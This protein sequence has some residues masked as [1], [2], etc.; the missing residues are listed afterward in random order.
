MRWRTRR[1]PSC[2]QPCVSPVSSR[3]LAGSVKKIWQAT[4][5]TSASLKP[6]SRGAR[7]SGATRMSLFSS[8]TISFLAARNT[9]LEPPPNPRFS[10]WSIP[11]TSGNL[12]RRKP[13]LPSLEPLSTTRISLAG[14]PASAT[15]MLGMYLASRSFPFQLGM[16]TV[17]VA[18]ALLAAAS[19]LMPTLAFDAVSCARTG[20]ETSLD[21][22]G[23][24][25]EGTPCATSAG[26]I[27][28]PRRVKS[29]TRTSARKLIAIRNGESTSSGSARMRRFRKAMSKRGAEAYLAPQPDPSGGANHVELVL[30]LA[31]LLLQP[32]RPRGSLLQLRFG[33]LQ[34][35]RSLCQR[36]SD[37]TDFGG[38]ADFGIQRPPGLLPVILLQV[39]N[40]GV[41]SGHY[42]PRVFLVARQLLLKLVDARAARG[43]GGVQLL[44]PT[45]ALLQLFLLFAKHDQQLLVLAVEFRQVQLRLVQPLVLRRQ[46]A[47]QL[48]DMVLAFAKHVGHPRHVKKCRVADLR[49]V[50]TDGDEEMALVGNRLGAI[51]PGFHGIAG[52]MRLER[53]ALHVVLQEHGDVREE[54]LELAVEFAEIEFVNVV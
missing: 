45:V 3:S 47:F 6:S 11:V 2:H 30:Q 4:A 8:T 29:C 44:R 53:D 16:T 9:A 49:A 38:K 37:L 7:K 36:R 41:V 34:G 10:A 40:L 5:N 24:G 50:G 28:P 54:L 22:A 35:G 46:L 12:P 17:A 43:Q 19:A 1:L 25:P 18:Q 42:P 48:G 51:H 52:F 13:A 23:T 21:T 32:E 15:R 26:R 33:L 31:P 27:L 14:F 20:V 39:G